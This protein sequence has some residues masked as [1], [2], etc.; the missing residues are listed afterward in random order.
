MKDVT[1][2]RGCRHR[3]PRGIQV[4]TATGTKRDNI[5][6][7]SHGPNLNT[8]APTFGLQLGFSQSV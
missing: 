8:F 1:S 7:E 2:G 5:S 6:A 4:N 3:P